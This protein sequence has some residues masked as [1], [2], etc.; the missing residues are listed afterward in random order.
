M[1]G[2]GQRPELT[3]VLP[4]APEQ[5]YFHG[6]IGQWGEERLFLFFLPPLV[7]LKVRA[8]VFPLALFVRYRRQLP[9]EVHRQSGDGYGAV[10]G[11][12]KEYRQH[13]ED[14]NVP[15]DTRHETS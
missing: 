2:E 14:A 12:D 15:K 4:D 13:T 10:D 6:H 7:L 3:V 5:Q 1:E 9:P 11:D 8:A